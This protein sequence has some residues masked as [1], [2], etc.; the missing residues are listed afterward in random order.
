MEIYSI[1]LLK[2]NIQNA[3]DALDPE[4]DTEA[5]VL[6]AD[7]PVLG[8]VFAKSETSAPRGWIA[9]LNAYID[10]AI[11]DP[12]SSTVSAV[13]I[14][15]YEQKKFAFTFGHGRSLLK[16]TAWVRGFGLKVALNR[17]SISKLRSLDTK[18]H[19]DLVVLTRKQTSSSST[20]ANFELDIGRALLKGVTGDVEN[21]DEIIRL[22]GSDIVRVT[23]ELGWDEIDEVLEQVMAAYNDTVYLQNFAWV[24]RIKETDPNDVA[25]LDA[26]LAQ[27]LTTLQPPTDAYLAPADIVDWEGLDH[28]NYTHGPRNGWYPDLNIEQYLQ[29][30]RA[31]NIAI[32]VE[33]LKAHKVRVRSMDEEVFHDKWSVYDCIVWETDMG[34]R[35]FVLFD[36]RWFEV[37]LNYA[38]E[39]RNFVNG[40]QQN[41]FQFPDAHDEC[42]EDYLARVADEM[43][44]LV[45]LLDQQGFRP[46]D[47]PTQIEFCDLLGATG[48]LIHIKIKSRSATLSHLFSQG[49]VSL[50]LFL[51][52]ATLRNQ[53]RD[54]L[55]QIGYPHFSG[56]IPVG[57]PNGS[58]F[59]VIFGIV[60]PHTQQGGNPRLPFFSSVNLMHHARR[61]QARG[62]SVSY[63]FIRK[64]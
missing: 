20:I 6:T 49:S 53:V 63:Q 46:H 26:Q 9:T 28:F 8:T 2:D 55:A 36:G 52:D 59:E 19:E 32:T 10:P 60:V 61:I 40:I 62:F 24:D 27:S 1:F 58:D 21:N 50:E 41:R 4:K 56:L 22:T 45:A 42:E 29:N 37:D 15:E 3:A 33:A 25:A 7:F 11:E 57:P 16:P 12:E 18:V 51:Q 64:V 38:A 34:A 23:T 43:P 13:M 17:V 47:S 31:K 44:D 48:Q 14:V 35:K 39:V 30:L 54:A 5:H